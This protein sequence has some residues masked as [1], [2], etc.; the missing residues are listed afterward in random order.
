MSPAKAA[1]AGARVIAGSIVHADAAVLLKVKDGNQL[2]C[3]GIYPLTRHGISLQLLLVPRM[4][5][6]SP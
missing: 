4:Q 2:E 6:F 5:P 1:Q 3:T